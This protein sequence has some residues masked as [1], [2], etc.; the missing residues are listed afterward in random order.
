MKFPLSNKGPDNGIIKLFKTVNLHEAATF[1]TVEILDICV[2]ELQKAM[3]R[4]VADIEL[5]YGDKQWKH[6]SSFKKFMEK[7]TNYPIAAFM[8]FIRDGS[9][10][11]LIF[12]N[13]KLNKTKQDNSTDLIDIIMVFPRAII[14]RGFLQNLLE[15]IFCVESFDYGYVCF[16]PEKYDVIF[17]NKPGRG[18]TEA[19]I[20][21]TK[22]LR[23][24]KNGFIKDVYSINIL[25]NKQ[26][27]VN[28]FREKTCEIYDIKNSGL[29]IVMCDI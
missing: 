12:N 7:E 24:I 25:S 11:S 2:F 26:I 18:N 4:E 19:E 21:K 13:D 28:K 8:S 15:K 17:E 5:N 1:K 16:L 9:C 14:T 23:D 6:Y 3:G 20:E 29:K 10:G 22:Q 27:E